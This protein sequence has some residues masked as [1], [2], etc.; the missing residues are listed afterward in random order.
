VSEAAGQYFA[1]EPAVGSRPAGFPL[2]L[3]DLSLQLTADRGVFAA[4]GV[5]PGTKLLLLESP[6]PSGSCLAPGA[7]LVD[8]G[9]GYGP[10]ALALARRAPRSTVW[11]V[12]VNKRARALCAANA[13]AN[14]LTNVVVVAPDEVPGELAVAGIWSN[15]PIRIGK[16]ALH[17]LLLSWLARLDRSTDDA[18]AWL[19]VQRHLGADS[20]QAWLT[21][22]GWPTTRLGSR[23]AF[24]LLEVRP[25]AGA[26]VGDEHRP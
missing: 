18:G 15:P 17:A 14:D 8:L 24:R 23:R 25:G 10:I 11:A 20:L 12:D 9:C 26:D 1:E 16:P 2:H 22:Q 13:A 21:D 5:D 7:N 19:V 6:W 3:P 4:G